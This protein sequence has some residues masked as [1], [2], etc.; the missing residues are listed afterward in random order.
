ML[1]QRAEHDRRARFRQW[2]ATRPFW[3]GVFLTA[4]GAMLLLPALATVEV[5]DLLISISTIAGVSTLMLGSMMLVC[6]FSVL[7]RAEARVPA[8]VAAMILALVALPA[9]NFGGYVLGSLFGVIGSA[10]TLAWAAAK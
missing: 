1:T 7:V 6:A 5:G 8:G 9:A 3:G 2:R 4:S 10:A